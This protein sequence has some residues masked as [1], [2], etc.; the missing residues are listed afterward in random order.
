MDQSQAKATSPGDEF[1]GQSQWNRRSL[2]R[3]LGGASLLGAAV[4]VGP[5][6]T[7]TAFAQDEQGDT[8]SDGD[9]GE[10]PEAAEEL[11]VPE[12]TRADLTDSDSSTAGRIVR[13]TDDDRSIWLDTG[14]GWVSLSGEAFNVRA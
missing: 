1:R 3:G 2:L 9:A 10:R 5:S 14:E 4:A 6:A 7:V 8:P 12:A 11:V 13:L